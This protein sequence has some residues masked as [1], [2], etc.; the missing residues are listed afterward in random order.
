MKMTCHFYIVYSLC[1]KPNIFLKHDPPALSITMVLKDWLSDKGGGHEMMSPSIFSPSSDTMQFV[2]FWF[3]STK[4]WHLTFP[5]K[6]YLIWNSFVFFNISKLRDTHQLLLLLV[7][8]NKFVTVEIFKGFSSSAI[9]R[10]R[11]TI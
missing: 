10:H 1:W 2:Q 7:R 4:S 5:S 3:S 8:N 11:R 6:Q 9:Q